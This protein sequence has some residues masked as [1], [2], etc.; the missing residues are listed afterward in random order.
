MTDWG[1]SH[2]MC[3]SY[4][5]AWFRCEEVISGDL[6]NIKLFSS[7]CLNLKSRSCR[8]LKDPDNYFKVRKLTF[9]CNFDTVYL[10]QAGI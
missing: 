8:I 6:C 2:Q 10:N 9:F 7:A 3:V 5:S 4:N 1:Y